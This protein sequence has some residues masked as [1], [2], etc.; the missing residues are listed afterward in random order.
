MIIWVDWLPWSCVIVER[1]NAMNYFFCAEMQSGLLVSQHGQ[2]GLKVWGTF[3]AIAKTSIG[4]LMFFFTQQGYASK[5]HTEKDL[6][7]ACPNLAN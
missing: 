4:S 5:H 7:Q 1:D 2:A 6:I 3:L